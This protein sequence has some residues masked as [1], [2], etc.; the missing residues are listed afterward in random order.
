MK[1]LKINR[2]IIIVFIMILSLS[3]FTA[4]EEGP[5]FRI[6]EYPEQTVTGIDQASGYPGINVTITGTN[7]GTLKGAVKVYFGG[8]LATNVVSCEDTKIVVQVPANA[9]SGDVTLQ[10]WKHTNEAFAQFT[11]FPAPA[12]KSVT[13]NNVI[14]TVA[15]P[16][17]DIVT[18][19]GVNFGSDASKVVVSFNGTVAPIQ[20]ITDTKITVLA[21]ANYA[22]GF[23]SITMGGLTISGTPAIVN[24]TAP[25]DITPYFMSNTGVMDAK[26]GGFARSAYDG[27]RWGTLAAPWITNAAGLNKAGR[28]GY[29]REQ[30]NGRDGF[31]CWETWGNTPVVDGTIYQPT[32]MPLPAGSYTLTLNYYGEIQTDSSVYLV[33]AAGGSGI[34]VLANISTAL[35]SVML[36]NGTTIGDTKPNFGGEVTLDFNLQTSQVVSIGFLGNM[37]GRDTK[38]NYFLGKW[39][40]LV[41]K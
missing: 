28:G 7:F 39:V 37:K 26:G 23:V 38:G 24:P 14:N 19:N 30:W 35:A 16:E 18:I 33:V 25:G 11:V 34:P 41:K 17:V 36:Y 6:V 22:T 21:P 3:F 10:V 9:I 31:I 40:K 1:I 2:T 27:S 29:G 15:F 4:C 5:D 32:S 12:I 13:S 20:T 8:I